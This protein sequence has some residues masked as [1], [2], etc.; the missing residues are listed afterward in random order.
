MTHGRRYLLSLMALIAAVAVP[1]ILAGLASE[2]LPAPEARQVSAREVAARLAPIAARVERVRELRFE[3]IPRAEIITVPALRRTF[4]RQL[5]QGY[6]AAKLRADEAALK[7]LGLLGPDESLQGLEAGLAQEVIGAYDPRNGRL[8]VV[9]APST[10]SAA[11]VDLTL[12]HEL[13]HA[14][15]DQR[16]GL[17]ESDELSDD[18]GLAQEALTEGSATE[19]MLRY[20]E[21][22]VDLD[23]LLELATDPDLV[24]G[25]TNLPE[26]LEAQTSFAY[27]R[28]RAFVKSL[29]E[30]GNDWDL[31]DIALRSR[32]PLST[33]QILHPFK[34]LTY[35]RPLPVR[36]HAGDELS[37]AWRHLTG[38]VLGELDTYL[39]LREVLGASAR[40]AAAG[41]GGQR[42]Q[43]WRRGA[44]ACAAPCTSRDVLIAAWRWDTRRDA[45]QFGRALRAY[46]VEGLGASP[47]GRQLW[48]HRG[49]WIAADR[50]GA[51]TTLAFAPSG[52]LARRLAGS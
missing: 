44:S 45:R 27:L 51:T 10:E 50:S 15:E 43:L 46:L 35:E 30:V 37:P 22:F 20:A 42:T 34:Y 33:E 38:G 9:R 17:E 1:L 39:L 5:A 24:A 18:R 36:L 13:D 6:P 7:L 12:A 11:V 21:R 3:R 52:F 14:L 31:V 29:W 16:F 49:A 4:A 41:W 26:L 2:P 48:S 32:P 8:Y 23:T 47:A 19:V 40:R 25:G 28:G